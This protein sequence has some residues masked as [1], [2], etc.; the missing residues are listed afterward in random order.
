MAYARLMS[1]LRAGG[2]VDDI[3]AMGLGIVDGFLLDKSAILFL[4]K[5]IGVPVLKFAGFQLP[6]SV[7][8]E[9]EGMLGLTIYAL[10]TG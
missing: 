2:I 1:M 9:S 3:I 4:V 5:N 7:V 8:H 6:A 10:L